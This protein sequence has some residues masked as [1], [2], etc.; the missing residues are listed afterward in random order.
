MHPDSIAFTAQDFKKFP[1]LNLLQV[2]LDYLGL[3]TARRIFE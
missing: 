1:N 3:K 2:Q